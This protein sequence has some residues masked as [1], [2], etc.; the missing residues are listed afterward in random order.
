[1]ERK[2]TIEEIAAKL[3]PIFGKKIDEIYLKYAMADSRE[4]REEITSLL[5]ALYKKYLSDLLERKVLLEPPTKEE[6]QG[7]YNLGKIFY[8]DKE[9]YDFSLREK[10]W[11][12]HVCITGMSGSGKTTLA[13]HI[14][15]NFLHKKKPFLIFD[16]KK[17]FRPLILEDSE[18]MDFTIG[19][20][21][22]SNFFKIN[23]NEPPEGVEPKEWINILCDLLTESFMVSF[24]VHKVLIETLDEAFKEWGIYQGSKNYPTWNHIKWRLEQKLDKT[25]GRESTWLESALRIASILTFGNFGKVCNYKGEN[26]M[27]VID[28]LD[29]KVIF[30]LNS[31]SNIEKKFFCEFVLIYIFK[32]KKANQT[33]VKDE[34]DHAILVDEAHNIFLKEKT[35]F[36]SE[37]VTDMVYREMREYGT[38]LICLDQHI[39]KLSDTVKGNSA[40]HIAFQQQLPEDVHDISGIMQ[41]TERKEYF[42]K[43]NIGT[44]IV[45]LAERYTSPFLIKV[46]E[47]KL[48]KQGVKDLEIKKRM[49]AVLMQKEVEEGRDK[50]FREKIAPDINEIEES[51]LEKRKE[52]EKESKEKFEKLKKEEEP[53]IEKK[54]K[55]RVPNHNLYNGELKEAKEFLIDGEKEKTIRKQITPIFYPTGLTPIQERL[56]EF[57]EKQLALGKSM[58]EIERIMEYYP[59]EGLYTLEDVSKV[60]NYVL[61]SRFNKIRLEQVPEINKKE[62]VT[63]IREQK[64]PKIYK[65]KKTIKKHLKVSKDT[66][67]QERFLAFLQANPNHNLS[68]VEVY[69]KL[70]LSARKG[71][72]IKD[73]LLTLGKVKII[74]QRSKKG[75]KKIIRLA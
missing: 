9:L 29:K 1:M 39:S 12:R 34:F 69:K 4:E 47:A 57:I 74:E 65:E 26:S 60:I 3:K 44:A 18:I 55:I 45:K 27:R 53:I 40:C 13:F 56:L 75:W 37:S 15:K 32:S 66:F 48:K 22:V 62:Y 38:S 54:E 58:A 71:T 33:L 64:K 42:S 41:L 50:E 16:W 5:N 73:E 25:I 59:S 28:L 24:G 36:V 20:D 72:R 31:L 70:G 7:E 43:L 52:L 8:A 46:E 6:I 19:N 21:G 14:I 11:P 2:L 30:E 10:D 67:E 51:I 61:T 49:Q 63:T 35:M 23:I 68:S 17:S